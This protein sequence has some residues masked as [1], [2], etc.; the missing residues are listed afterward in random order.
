MAF[1]NQVSLLRRLGFYPHC[2][3]LGL[4]LGAGLGDGASY[5]VDALV[6][7]AWFVTRRRINVTANMAMVG[8]AA[9]T[10]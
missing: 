4:G 6:A 9:M 8:I 3:K 2:M 1:T 7:A 10:E 5:W